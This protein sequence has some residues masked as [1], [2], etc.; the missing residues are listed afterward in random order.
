MRN[1][2]S[3]IQNPKWKRGLLNVGLVL[4]G[5]AGTLVA[6]EGGIRV[7]CPQIFSRPKIWRY[8]AYLGWEHVPGA[9]ALWEG[10]DFKVPVEINSKGLRDQEY[11][12]RKAEGVFRILAFGDSYL[13]G[14]GV[15]L[16]DVVTEV[17][18]RRLND[19]GDEIQYEVLNCGVAGYGTDQEL[20][21][22]R[23][24]GVRYDPDLVVLFFYVN[25]VWNNYSRWGIGSERG[26][27]PYFEVQNRMLVLRGVPVPKASYWEERGPRSIGEFLWARSHLYAFV[28]DRAT[29]EKLSEQSRRYYIGL[30]APVRPIP[31]QRAWRMTD[32]LVRAFAETCER[33]DAEFLLVFV[34]ARQQIHVEDWER[35]RRGLRLEGEFDLTEP[36]RTVSETCERMHVQFF[37]LLREFRRRTEEGAKLYHPHDTHWNEEGHRL[38]AELLYDLLVERRM[39]STEIGDQR[40][41]ISDQ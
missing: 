18:E 10:R 19:R 21:L 29:G 16:E 37:D 32:E 6:F 17:L 1:E 31:A 11:A 39:L 2:K 30:Y 20:L 38:T 4:A 35:R 5:L 15:R 28:M 41:V 33:M 22:L 25:D 34:P 13:E 3:E 23:R 27:K 40:S 8:D 24:E 7:V 14:W 36:N 9:R 12:Y 26:Y